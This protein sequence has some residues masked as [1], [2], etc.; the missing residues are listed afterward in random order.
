VALLL[1][2]LLL[3]LVVSWG[4]CGSTA[5]IQQSGEELSCNGLLL[6]LPS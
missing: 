2:L 1:L 3:L 5:A 6:L 4:R